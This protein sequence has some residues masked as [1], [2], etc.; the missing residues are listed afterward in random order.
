MS[1]M[2]LPPAAAGGSHMCPS[3]IDRDGPEGHGAA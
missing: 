2:G 3:S 1:E